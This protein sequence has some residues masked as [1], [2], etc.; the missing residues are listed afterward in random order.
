AGPAVLGVESQV[1]AVRRPVGTWTVLTPRDDIDLVAGGEPGTLVAHEEVRAPAT[2]RVSCDGHVP[3]G[4][5]FTM[6]PSAPVRIT[7]ATGGVLRGTV[8]TR[9]DRQPLGGIRAL[10]WAPSLSSPPLDLARRATVGG[11]ERG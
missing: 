11:D 6:P 4:R 8:I 7:L 3:T 10:A 5:W 9:A 1:A 2:L